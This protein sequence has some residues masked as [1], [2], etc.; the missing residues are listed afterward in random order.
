MTNSK[1]L[2]LFILSVPVLN[3]LD[4]NF[5]LQ[6]NLTKNEKLYLKTQL[7]LI[8][9]SKIDS[10]LFISAQSINNYNEKNNVLKNIILGDFHLYKEFPNDSLSLYKS[11]RF[12]NT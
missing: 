8:K 9:K 4:F 12:G 1:I 11:K 3:S 10:T 7:E 6:K 5:A 2:I